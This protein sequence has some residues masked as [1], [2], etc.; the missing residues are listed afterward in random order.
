M[1]DIDEFGQPPEQQ[2]LD[3]L[4]EQI[5]LEQNHPVPVLAPATPCRPTIF[6]IGGR[7]VIGA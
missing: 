2:F 4:L 1:T 6:R 3:G 5:E 7:I